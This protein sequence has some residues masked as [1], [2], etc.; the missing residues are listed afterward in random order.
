MGS[1]WG[2]AS[3]EECLPGRGITSAITTENLIQAELIRHYHLRQIA[4]GGSISLENS[5]REWIAKRAT[6]FRAYFIR[7]QIY[8]RRRG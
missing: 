5:A 1:I 2:S 4:R 6:K 7:R 8:G 3:G